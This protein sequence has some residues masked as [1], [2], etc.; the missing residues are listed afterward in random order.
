MVPGIALDLFYLGAGERE[1]SVLVLEEGGTCMCL[2]LDFGCR[3]SLC[4]AGLGQVGVR[5]VLGSTRQE[6]FN[7]GYS[8]CHGARG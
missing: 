7:W 1:R 6:G 8:L 4:G 3:A 5:G 2:A